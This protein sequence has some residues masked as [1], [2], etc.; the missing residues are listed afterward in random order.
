MSEVAVEIAVEQQRSPSRSSFNTFEVKGETQYE[1]PRTLEVGASHRLNNLALLYLVPTYHE[2]WKS[3]N[4]LNQVEGFLRQHPPAGKPIEINYSV[5]MDKNEFFLRDFEKNPDYQATQ[6][7]VDVLRRIVR[8]QTLQ[9]D[10]Q[11]AREAGMDSSTLEREY[12]EMVSTETDGRVRALLAMAAEKAHAVTFSFIDTSKLGNASHYFRTLGYGSAGGSLPSTYRTFGLDYAYK[13]KA[14]IVH[15]MDAD[16]LLSSNRASADI[17]HMYENAPETKFHV[18]SLTYQMAGSNEDIYAD[19]PTVAASRTRNYNMGMT[20]GGNQISF[21]HDQIQRLEAISSIFASI[22]LGPF[23]NAWEDADTVAHLRL[24]AEHPELPYD[25]QY[26]ASTVM[27]MD[28]PGGKWDGK[29]R[30]FLLSNENF[31][32]RVRESL[33]RVHDIGERISETES[34]N[35]RTRM[36]R[37]YALCKHKYG[38]EIEKNVRFMRHA[39]REFIQA[40]DRGQIQIRDGEVEYNEQDM[41]SEALKRYMRVNRDFIGSLDQ[42]DI[43]WLKYILE[44]SDTPPQGEPTAKQ[45]AIREWFGMPADIHMLYRESIIREGIH[46]ELEDNRD[47]Y[48]G[49]SEEVNHV[50]R[51]ISLLHSAEIQTL[52]AGEIYRKYFAQQDVWNAFERGETPVGELPGVV[53]NSINNNVAPYEDRTKWLQ[54]IDLEQ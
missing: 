41:Q 21:R 27:T 7:M 36:M 9:Q 26:P 51:R 23:S 2:E 35:Q 49:D 24:L 53:Q 13:R 47:V 31:L 46:E 40:V 3:G 16:T 14:G 32:P 43:T 45:K 10:L 33:G 4:F 6:R 22:G 28:R 19:S 30:H 20:G 34:D 18:G 25:Y 48:D 29:A 50:V 8:V 15:L 11:K 17:I 5:N 37:D 38:Q 1:E 42:S 52:A 39:G 44:L 54:G 12:Q